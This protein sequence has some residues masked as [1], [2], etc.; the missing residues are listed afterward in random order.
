MA[1]RFSEEEFAKLKKI[2]I[3]YEWGQRSLLTKLNI[4][5]EDFNNFQDN[6]PIEN[7]RGRVKAP[8]SIAEKL[9][10]M[11]VE[12]TAE[13]AKKY[14]KD[15]AGVRIICAFA[16]DIF[17]LVD[18]LKSMPGISVLEERDYIKSPKPSGYRSYHIIMEVPVFYSGKNELV[19][20]EVQIRTEAMNFWSTLEHKARYKYQEHIPRQLCDELVECAD[21]ISELDNRMYLIHET[22]TLINQED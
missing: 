13:N 2:L 22:I 16:K 1:I 17:Y 21:K 10:D 14:L 8:E 5:Y 15:I 3:V 12:I 20:V 9:H 6:N 19:K 18:L 4:M 11:K 7:I